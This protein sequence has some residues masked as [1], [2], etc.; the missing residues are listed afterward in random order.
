MKI[1]YELDLNS[2]NAWSGAE[3]TL[4][5]VLNAGKVEELEILLDECYPDGMTETEL[6][7]LLRFEPDTIYRWLGMKTEDELIEGI[8]EVDGK[9]DEIKSE[10]DELLSD[11]NDECIE[12]IADEKA[13][14]LW[15]E[16][17]KDRYNSLKEDLE[18]LMETLEELQEE[19]DNLFEC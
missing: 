6:N 13:K 12:M 11:Y 7:D 18:P 10:I 1:T 5:R 9:I 8:Q 3:N 2:F 14:E 4:R 15:E 19:Y 17:Y 16:D